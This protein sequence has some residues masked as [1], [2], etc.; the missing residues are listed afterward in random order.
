MLLKWDIKLF[1]LINDNLK[2]PFLDKVMPY[3]TN[4]G[5]AMATFCIL[6]VFSFLYIF[7]L[8]KTL[9]ALALTQ[10]IVQFLKQHISRIRPYE[11]LP[12]VNF[13]HNFA[14]SDY[15]FPSGHSATIFCIATMAS[16]GVP[17]LAPV[18][19]G[20]ALLVAISRIYLGLH[21]PSDVMVG[22]VIGWLCAAMVLQ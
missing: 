19:F 16:W 22:S 12:D 3:F 2:T 17:W 8:Q 5:G 13:D 11:A 6:V 7:P 18:F 9:I 10:I 20:I 14:L 15:S 21:F 4:L 1:N